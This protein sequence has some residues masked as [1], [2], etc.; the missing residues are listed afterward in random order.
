MG[1]RADRDLRLAIDNVEKN[2]L[3]LHDDPSSAPSGAVEAVRN[4]WQAVVERLALGPEPERRIC[5]HCGGF[6]RREAIRCIHCWKPSPS[7]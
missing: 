2:L 3:A 4:A 5:P 6:V 1:E 7:E